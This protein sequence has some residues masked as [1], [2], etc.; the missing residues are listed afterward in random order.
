[1]RTFHFAGD[2]QLWQSFASLVAMFHSSQ[3]SLP[4]PCWHVCLHS[5]KLRFREVNSHIVSG[6]TQIWAGVKTLLPLF[7]FVDSQGETAYGLGPLAAL[8][9]VENL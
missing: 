5:G 8:Y 6:R 7:H 2:A 3:D 1:M 9:E 4:G